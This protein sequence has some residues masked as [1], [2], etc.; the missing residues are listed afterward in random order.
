VK[1]NL[2][3]SRDNTGRLEKNIQVVS[4]EVGNADGLGLASLNK[5]FHSTVCD[6]EVTLDLLVEIARAI[7]MAR[8]ETALTGGQCDRPA[9]INIMV[10]QW[11]FNGIC[12][13]I[14]NVR[15]AV[16]NQLTSA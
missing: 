14:A 11:C 13:F 5:L 7:R 12:I 16:A 2:V 3:D 10:S 4:R 8:E 15:Q 6:S 1:L 9:N